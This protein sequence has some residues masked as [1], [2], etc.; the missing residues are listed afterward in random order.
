MKDV[1]ILVRLHTANFPFLDAREDG[2]DL[3]FVWA[4]D[5]TPLKFHVE[6]Y[7]ATNELAAVWVRVPE[8]DAKSASQFIWLYFGNTKAQPAADAAGTFDSATGLVLHFSERTGPPLDLSSFAHPVASAGAV[9]RIADGFIAAGMHFGPEARLEIDDARGMQSGDAGVSV[10]GW[11]RVAKSPERGVIVAWPGD[12]SGLS[13]G[14]DSGRLTAKL[15]GARVQAREV[16]SVGAWH[17]FALTAGDKLTLYVDGSP[18]GRAD[19]GPVSLA[20]PFVIGGGGFEGDLDE[21]SVAAVARPTPWVEAVYAAQ[22]GSG[23]MV[24]IGEPEQ[25]GAGGRTY[26]AILLSAVTTD[27]WVV[28]GVLVAMLVLSVG[29]MVNKAWMLLVAEAANQRFLADFQGQPDSML[30]PAARPPGT[31][32]Y[33]H[34]PL[35]RLWQLA[36]RELKDRLDRYERRG[37]PKVLSPQSLSAIKAALDAGLVRESGRLNAQ[38]VLLTIAISGGPFLGLLGT[39]TGV[40]ITF[41]AIA[42]AGDVNV[43]SIAPGIAAALVAT[44]AGLAV[45]IP[46]LFGYNYLASRVRRMTSEM[47]VFADELVTRLAEAYSD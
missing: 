31:G 15:G 6:S 3:R 47:E 25:R 46:S 9:Q 27:G 35:C 44:V 42:A 28:I 10:S 43:N 32:N 36:L 38:M 16:L 26:L 19:A 12:G 8:I 4:D 23:N 29:V 37:R 1:P 45:A 11:V 39:V 34:A 7:D 30:D 14:L 41:A 18:Q 2:A 22:A 5:K 40:M 20:P 21:M 24:S 17:A 33:G 13:L